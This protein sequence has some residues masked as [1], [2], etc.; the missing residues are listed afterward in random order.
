MII[1][2]LLPD[3]IIKCDFENVYAPSND[4]YLLID[5]FKSKI[6]HIYF[7]G[8]KISEIN[9]ILD[10]GTGTGIIAIFFQLIKMENPNFNPKIYA[11][12][13]LEDA[14]KCAK[15]NEKRNNIDNK[16]Q[17]FHSDLF[18]SFPEN[19]KHSFNILVFNPPYLPS[20]KFIEQNSNKQKIDYSWDGGLKGYKIIVEFL[21]AAKIFLNLKKEHF[22]Y[23]IT[24]SRTDLIELNRIF[25]NL[26]Y[27]NRIVEKEH[28]F[29]EDIVL[30]RLE[31]SRY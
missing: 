22:I 23:C 13:I 19:L 9:N 6:D 28:I 25:I 17:I 26:G 29:F 27:K 16:I 5:Y 20:S 1:I 12:D 21:S 18:N 14:I 31:Y 11:S 24:S 15:L 10:L 2:P 30:N 8:I 3:P 4:S 7:D